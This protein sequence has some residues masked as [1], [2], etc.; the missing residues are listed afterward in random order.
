LPTLI[1][2]SLA[3]LAICVTLVACGGG[4]EKATSGSPE[5]IRALRFAGSDLEYVL[6]RIAAEAGLVIAIDEIAPKDLSPDLGLVRVDIDLPAGPVDD[7]LRRVKQAVPLFDYEIKNGVI[8]ARSTLLISTN[9]PIDVPVLK[10]KKFTG[11]LGQL[12]AG[13]MSELPASFISVQYVMGG[14]RGE[15]A[16][17]EL[18]DNSSVKD[19]L[20]E[21]ARQSKTNWIMHRS[22]QVVKNTSQG[23]AIVGTSIEPRRPRTSTLRLPDVRN[24]LSTIGALADASVRLKQPIVVYD[25]SVLMGTRGILNLSQQVDTVGYG[26]KETLDELGESG[27]GPTMWH[28]RW[29]MEDGVPVVRSSRFL[30]FLRGRDVLSSELLGGDFEGTLPELARWLNTHQKHPGDEV[31]MGGEIVDGMPKGKITVASGTTVHQALI[32]FAKASGISPHVVVLE[33]T[34]PIGGIAIDHP[35]A[36]HGAYLQDLAE[37]IPTAEDR[38]RHDIITHDGDNSAK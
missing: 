16:S 6:E 20:I 24:K 2:R 19:A 7:A 3:A 18:P 38:I 30:Y 15:V 5:Q 37:W 10:H 25:R 28:F 11:D 1:H 36:W 12:V 31:L 27:F 33:L 13:L 21:Y 9:T 22:S 35:H 32:Q 29:R 17:M 4:K 14:P 23:M 8:Y 34:S 26:V